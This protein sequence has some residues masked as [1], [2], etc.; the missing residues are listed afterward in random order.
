[1]VFGRVVKHFQNVRRIL[2]TYRLKW[3]FC[4]PRTI[5]MCIDFIFI[6]IF[7]AD[8]KFGSAFRRYQ[9][10]PMGK[11]KLYF[12][13]CRTKAPE[14]IWQPPENNSINIRTDPMYPKTKIVLPYVPLS[15][16]PRVCNVYVCVVIK[17]YDVLN[18]TNTWLMIVNCRITWNL[19]LLCHC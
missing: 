8:C 1:M 14:F 7:R 3:H 12:L 10:G 15:L 19:S 4:I 13:A 5:D 11:K 18:F 16:I 2:S 17:F 9:F 6:S